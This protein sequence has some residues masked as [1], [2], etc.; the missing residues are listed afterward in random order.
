M[1]SPDFQ[2]GLCLPLLVEA[3]Q[4]HGLGYGGGYRTHLVG[5]SPFLH[6]SV[7]NLQ[8]LSCVFLSVDL[9]GINDQPVRF[10][11]VEVG[12][13]RLESPVVYNHGAA[14]CACSA[15]RE[16]LPDYLNAAIFFCSGYECHLFSLWIRKTPLFKAGGVD[17]EK[18]GAMWSAL[19]LAA[20]AF[21]GRLISGIDFCCAMAAKA[22]DNAFVVSGLLMSLTCWYLLIFFMVL[23]KVATFGL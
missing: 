5:L 8:E 4:L 11:D 15:T 22:R 21:V 3:S 16:Q 18:I 2:T 23:D 13:A 6:Y 10:L 14:I 19:L 20:Y 9:E 1:S 12:A 7:Q 17:F